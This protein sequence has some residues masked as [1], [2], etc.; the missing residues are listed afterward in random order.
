MVHFVGGDSLLYDA[1][2][3]MY[4]VRVFSRVGSL[5]RAGATTDGWFALKGNLP[6]VPVGTSLRRPYRYDH[7]VGRLVK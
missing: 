1:G 6:C 2:G 3:V 4:R 5:E 7:K